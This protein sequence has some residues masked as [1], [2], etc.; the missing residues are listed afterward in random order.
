M[1]FRNCLKWVREAT[2][3]PDYRDC[4]QGVKLPYQQQ[5]GLS[6][7]NCLEVQG[8]RAKLFNKTDI[9]ALCTARWTCNSLTCNSLQINSILRIFSKTLVLCV[10]YSRVNR[11]SPALLGK[12]QDCCQH[13]QPKGSLGKSVPTITL[14]HSWFH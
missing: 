4:K 9:P 2:E 13:P 14:V 6:K 12:L 10:N 7:D 1:V 8:I 3:G 5:K 11:E